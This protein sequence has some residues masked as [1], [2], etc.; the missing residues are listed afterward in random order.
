MKQKNTL[1]RY[2]KKNIYNKKRTKLSLYDTLMVPK[3]R[4]FNNFLNSEYKY[5]I[6]R[7]TYNY[8]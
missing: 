8:F 6:H 4:T 3:E 2:M 7:E 1:P 5:N